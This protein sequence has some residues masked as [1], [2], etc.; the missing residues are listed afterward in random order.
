MKNKNRDVNK[1]VIQKI[2]GYCDIINDLVKRFDSSFDLYISD[3][4][5]QLS[6]NMCILQIGELTKHLSDDF[7]EKYSEIPWH[8]IKSMRNIHAHEYEKVNFEYMWATLTEDIPELKENLTKIL[9][10]MSEN[11]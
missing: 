9:D 6:C 8:D 4:A 10:E 2:I 7:K 1:I 11:R 3:M 5:F